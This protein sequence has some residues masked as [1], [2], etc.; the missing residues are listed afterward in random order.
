MVV[1]GPWGSST[2]KGMVDEATQYRKCNYVL[3]AS[4][5]DQKPKD[6]TLYNFSATAD[7]TLLIPA[8]CQLAYKD[9]KANPAGGLFQRSQHRISSDHRLGFRC[10]FL[11][12]R[13]IA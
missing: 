5:T 6:F 2:L 1:L 10:H 4:K 11:D 12:F 9:L 8:G 7:D 13:R 3:A